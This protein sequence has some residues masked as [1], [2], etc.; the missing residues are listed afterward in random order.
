PERDARGRRVP[1]DPP[2]PALVPM[3]E[4]GVVAEHDQ[5]AA[6]PQRAERAERQR[7]AEPV[8]RDVHAF[9]GERA[10]PGQEVLVAVV[11]RHRAE[12]RGRSAGARSRAEAVPYRRSPASAPSS[13]TAVPTRPAAPCTSTVSPLSAIANR[14]S[15]W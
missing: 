13:S 15:S 11:D 5:P 10:D 8:E 3:R 6:G 4:R 7:A 9:L 12:P 2:A 14:W 1:L